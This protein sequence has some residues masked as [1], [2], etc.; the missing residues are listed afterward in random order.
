MSR[1]TINLCNIFDLFSE[2]AAQISIK[3]SAVWEAAL[4]LGRV[5]SCSITFLEAS[6]QRF[7]KSCIPHKLIEVMLRS[8]SNTHEGHLWLVAYIFGKVAT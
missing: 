5:L 3:E 1:R 6:L 2:P 4:A 7:H 8:P